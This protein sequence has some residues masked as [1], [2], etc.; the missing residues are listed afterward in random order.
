MY[1]LLLSSRYLRT[2][3][4]ALASIIS[5]MLGVATMIVV[6]SVMSG[7]ATQMRDRI[8]G[9]NADLM[10]ESISL[11]GVENPEALMAEIEEI[12]GEYIA[13]MTPAVEIYGLVSFEWAGQNYHRPATLFGIIPEGK[14]LVSPLRE[15]L[16]SRQ[17]IEE[18]GV[19][20]SPPQRDPNEPLDWELTDDALAW[21]G[22]EGLSANAVG[23]GDA[24][25]P[26]RR[27]CLGVGV[28]STDDNQS[29]SQRPRG[30][31]KQQ[32]VGHRS[33]AVGAADRSQR[34][35]PRPMLHRHRPGELSVHE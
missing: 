11:D 19:L 26:G 16:L 25:Q 30:R 29:V 4:I 20:V 22:M 28:G 32:S 6:N 14:D 12:A 13:A 2:R 31:T 8:H 9:I 10:V 21:R 23:A 5:V 27:A 15:F 35:A 7:F 17:A 33:P 24:T 1:K 18:D 3:F 34:P